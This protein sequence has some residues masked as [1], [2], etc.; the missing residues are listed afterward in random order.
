[1]PTKMSA[2]EINGALGKLPG[3]AAE[4]EDAIT[5][6]FRLADHI[7]AMGFVV[8]IAMAAEVMDHHPELRIVYNTVDVRLNTHSAGGVTDLDLTLAGHVDEIAAALPQA[9]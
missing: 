9:G 7:H 6:T 4:G 5:K 1:M 3:W 8:Q 2:S